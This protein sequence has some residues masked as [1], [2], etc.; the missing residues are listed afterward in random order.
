MLASTK[1]IVLLISNRKWKNNQLQDLTYVSPAAVEDL[2]FMSLVYGLCIHVLCFKHFVRGKK[3][4]ALQNVYTCI[5]LIVRASVSL[6]VYQFA[7]KEI[8]VNGWPLSDLTSA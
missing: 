3:F 5:L 8:E 7:G 2:R 6:S 4:N 1:Y